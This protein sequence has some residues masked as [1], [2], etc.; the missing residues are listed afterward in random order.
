MLIEV[1]IEEGDTIQIAATGDGVLAEPFDLAL[2]D[3]HLLGL[4]GVGG[5]GGAARA[6]DRDADCGQDPEQP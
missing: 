5:F 6:A 2:L 3:L 4:S 1:L